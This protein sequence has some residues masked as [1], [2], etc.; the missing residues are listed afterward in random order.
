MENEKGGK[1]HWGKSFIGERG[2]V[3]RERIS[4]TGDG[5]VKLWGRKIVRDWFRKHCSVR[6]C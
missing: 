4:S 1:E 3:R 2:K 6:R 5:M